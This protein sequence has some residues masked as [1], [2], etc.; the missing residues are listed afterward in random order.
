MSNILIEM[1]DRVD[2]ALSE[3]FNI[4]PI[5]IDGEFIKSAHSGFSQLKSHV[6]QQFISEISSY[7]P[8]LL[9]TIIVGFGR[10]RVGSTA[11]TNAIGTAGIPAHFQPFKSWL[12]N[13]LING[14]SPIP[15]GI[16][17]YQKLFCKE[18][19]GP[20]TRY[21]SVWNPI[22]ELLDVYPTGK[23]IGIWMERFPAE[24]LSSWYQNWDGLVN[25]D[26][27]LERFILS[28]IQAKKLSKQITDT[29]NKLILYNYD[30]LE[31]DPKTK[32]RELM[33]AADISI[34]LEF[35]PTDWQ[36]AGD[37]GSDSSNIIF[38]QEP[39]EYK[40]VAVHSNRP[41]YEFVKRNVTNL[42]EHD[43]YALQ[44]FELIQIYNDHYADSL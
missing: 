12:R 20:F 43:F 27:L 5:M 37:L 18:M 42:K 10:C 19:Y 41:K 33:I 32:L 11:L 7:S 23:I 3:Q 14:S 2:Y 30:K 38:C 13:T 16:F 24:S 31:S 36:E 1:R 4:D 29:K 28:T 21:E 6:R 9:P 35:D 8:K 26:A 40:P 17:D 25:R 15:N 22:E 34:E 44:E 39:Q